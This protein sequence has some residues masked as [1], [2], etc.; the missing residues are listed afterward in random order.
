MLPGIQTCRASYSRTASRAEGYTL[1]ELLVV[2]VLLG[3]ILSFAVLSIG[4]GGRKDKLELEARRLQA[5]FTLASEEAILQS[6]V[7]GVLLEPESYR[8]LYHI[9]DGWQVLDGPMFRSYR[10]P[11][12]MN[13]QLYQS[14][15]RVTLTT[16]INELDSSTKPQLLF[17]PGGERSAFEIQ[18]RYQDNPPLSYTLQSSVLG[19]VSLSLDSQNTI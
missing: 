9:P 14:S 10:L 12:N 13:L 11:E 3:I 17:H 5:L 7:I 16:L 6:M 19:K 8:F 18:I 4:D 2:L 1:L 15:T